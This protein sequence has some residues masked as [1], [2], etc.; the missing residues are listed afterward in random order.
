MVFLSGQHEV[1]LSR[2]KQHAD[3]FTP[4]APKPRSEVR[5]RNDT[6]IQAYR[7]FPKS[8][9]TFLLGPAGTGKSFVAMALAVREIEEGRAKKIVLTRPIVESG[10]SLGYLPGDLKAKTDEYMAPLFAQL[11]KLKEKE[12]YEFVKQYVEVAPIAYMRGRTFEDSICVFDEAQ[13]ATMRQLKM[14]LSRLGENSKIIITGDL[15]QKDIPNSGL[16]D[17]IERIHD[18]N[19]IQLLTFSPSDNVRHPVV[20]RILS[21]LP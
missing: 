4:I 12:R 17:V 10:E 21:R 9:V 19:G 3:E 2:K 11:D 13:N 6:Q 18:L 16:S 1:T 8:D 14:Y 7:V 5:L 20:E 15:D